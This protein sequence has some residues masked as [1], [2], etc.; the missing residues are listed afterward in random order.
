MPASRNDLLSALTSAEPLGPVAHERIVPDVLDDIVYDRIA[1]F[2]DIATKPHMLFLGRKG[3]GK[4]ALLSQIRLG[5]QKK[6][7]RGR[8]FFN[9]DPTPSRDYVIDVY[10]W[11]HFHQIVRNVNRL[12][13][14]DDV[15]DELIPS[16]YFAELW[17]QTLWGEIIEHFYNYHSFDDECRRLLEPVEK[18]V[19]ADGAFE[20]AAHVQALNLFLAAKASVLDFLTKR[21]SQLYFLFD[22]MENYPVRNPTFLKI[23]G[24]LFQGLSKISDESSHIT[25]SFCIP[26]EIENFFASSSANLMKDFASFYRIRWNP[27]DLVR[28]VAHRLRL[29]ASVHDRLLFQ[30]L[31]KLDFA[32]RD[33]LHF[34]FNLILPKAVTNA[35]GTVEDPLA[36]IIR[37]TQLLPRH[38]LAIFNAALSHHYRLTKT[39]RGLTEKAIRD[40]I[41]SVEKLIAK[42]ILMPYEQIYPKLLAQCTKILP[43]LTPI[44]DYNALRKV[45]GRFDRVIEDDV[46]G[47]WHTLFEIGILGRSTSHS[48]ADS[49]E[50]AHDDRYCYGQFHY[51]IDGAFSLPTHGEFCFHPVFTRAFGI[52]R[53]DTNDQRV[54]YPAHINFEDIYANA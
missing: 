28:V 33:D 13:K 2:R 36:Y 50:G 18:Y 37:H 17:Y 25:V 6:G 53:R 7:S 26:E 22:S 45:E 23:I 3:A 8:L 44:C 4:S 31:E 46:G 24:G 9:N 27:V 40:G 38:I 15:I 29:S 1:H 34:L 48:G 39:F 16:E 10:S 41:T 47:V 21:R 51:N 5:M 35:R 42:Q 20:G 19:N 11:E 43:D 32:K 52:V 14:N 49:H 30:E 12:L 54:V